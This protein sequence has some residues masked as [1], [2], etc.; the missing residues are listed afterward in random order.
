MVPDFPADLPEEISERARPIIKALLVQQAA[1]PRLSVSRAECMQI[2]AHG[3]S[4]QIQ[5]E[6]SGEYHTYVDGGSKRILVASIYARMIR[7]IKAT[8]PV[9][10]PPAKARE[11][12]TKFRKRARPRT[13]AEL[14]GLRKG[15]EAR[16]LEAERRRAAEAPEPAV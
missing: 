6:E 15:N 4:K 2:A 8:Y 1:D 10:G 12:A 14:E 3:L 5:L 9:A 11:V 16:R 13:A 7:Q